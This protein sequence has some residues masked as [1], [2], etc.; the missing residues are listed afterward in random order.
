MSDLVQNLRVFLKVA[1]HESFAAAGRDL[2]MANSSVT[3]QIAA[4][5]EELGAKLFVRSTRSVRLS[6]AGNEVYARA[7]N[8]LASVD[9]LKRDLHALDGRVSGTLRLSVPWRFARIYIAPLLNSFLKTYPDVRVEIVS[10][11][12]IVSLPDAGFDAAIRIGRL[13]DSSLIARKLDDQSFALAA[14][15]SYLS[16][17]PPIATHADLSDHAILSFAYTTSAFTWKLRHDG[18]THRLATRHSRL[19]TNNADLITEAAID[20]AGII[21]QPDWAIRDHLDSGALIR[22]LSDYEVTSTAF[23]TGIYAVYP[24]ENRNNPCVRA[25]VEHLTT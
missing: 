14:A 12:R 17:H 10:D 25:W 23:E 19:S 21:V 7:Q 4:L 2:N 24:A 3:R 16:D 13:A 8:L 6:P 18:Q 20:G 15:P 5:E 9:R 22:L 11:D 1:D